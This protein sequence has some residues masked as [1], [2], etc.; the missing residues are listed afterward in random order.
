M[1]RTRWNKLG[2]EHPV[3]ELVRYYVSLKPDVKNR[4]LALLERDRV[5]L[6]GDTKLELDPDTSESL[7]EYLKFRPLALADAE[8][9]LRSEKEAKDYC[10]KKFDE[11]P[12]TT[13]TRSQDHHQSARAVVLS[14][15][16]L[17]EAACKEHGVSLD[18]NPQTRCVWIA[19]KYLHV[20]ARNLDGAVPALLNPWLVWE[21]KEYWGVTKGGSKMSDAV[22]ECALVG[23]ELR[24]LEK[25]NNIHIEHAVILDG[26]EQW[27][28]RRSDLLRFCDLFFQGLIDAL[29]IGTEI[30]TEW[31]H[32]VENTIVKYKS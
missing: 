18:A 27:G 24:D 28:H 17:A 23:R 7:G 32:Y 15:S 3:W 14:V 16:R 30:E 11:I 29:F 2:W 20:T 13:R 1:R 26:R 19:G 4:F 22:Y 25:R 8:A 5:V 10:I 12:K 6:I 31:R 21:I 9:K